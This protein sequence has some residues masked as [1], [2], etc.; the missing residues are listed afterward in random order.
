MSNASDT[1]ESLYRTAVE[2]MREHTLHSSKASERL[3]TVK[4]RALDIPTVR[5][6]LYGGIAAIV[7]GGAVA[8]AVW[9]LPD[10][11]P[12]PVG[13]AVFGVG[14]LAVARLRFL[15]SLPKPS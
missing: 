15:D 10:C 4:K 8:P 12:L 5:R 2:T 14:L 13:L 11:W 9:G 7:T 6:L 1:A 3:A